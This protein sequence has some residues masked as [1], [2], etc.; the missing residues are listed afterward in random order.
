MLF[1]NPLCGRVSIE[2]YIAY[3]QEAV[4]AYMLR[5]PTGITWQLIRTIC[6]YTARSPTTFFG[7]T[8]ECQPIRYEYMYYSESNAPAHPIL[9]G[10][11]L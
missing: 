2:V 4:R 1:F 8:K 6:S 5:T 9:V 3:P 11:V 10:L 7:E